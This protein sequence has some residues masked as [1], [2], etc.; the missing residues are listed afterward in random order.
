MAVEPWRANALRAVTN[1][2]D[3]VVI[4]GA[5]LEAGA[6]ALAGRRGQQGLLSKAVSVESVYDAFNHGIA[7]ARAIEAFLGY[8]YRMWERGPRYVALLGSGTMD[9]RN[10]TGHGDAL[11]PSRKRGSAHGVYLSDR[12]Y[13]DVNKDGVMEMAVGR[14]PAR[15]EEEA[16]GYVLKVEAFEGGG[17]WRGRALVASDNAD[18]GG[19]YGADAAGLMGWLSGKAVQVVGLDTMPVSVARPAVKGALEAG[20]EWMIYVGHGNSR[21]M[22]QEG[23]WR[24]E[25]V[26]GLE[27]AGR[28]GIVAAMGCLMGTY[29]APGVPSL[30][31]RFVVG[32][33]GAVAVLSST[34]MVK[35]RIGVET[36]AAVLEATY[37]EGAEARLGD[38]WAAAQTAKRG[39][40]MIDRMAYLGDPALAVGAADAPRG[41]GGVG[42]VRPGYEE[43]AGWAFAPVWADMGISTAGASDP[44]GDG[45]SNAA[46]WMAGTDPM[47]EESEF[48]VVRVVPAAGGGRELRWTSAPGRRYAVERATSVTGPYS[49]IADDV[50]ATPSENRWTDSDTP[51]NSTFFYR[52]RVK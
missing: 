51:T 42:P 31:E 40:E 4:Y 36:A 22:A 25:D 3:Y 10:Y 12:V 39:E 43:W 7:D 33:K 19:A 34:W 9:Y 32:E 23:L 21:Q 49:V 47:D 41:D 48:A 30:G 50:A 16:L 17:E 44:D 18:G 28:A 37:G 14:I 27:N 8:A 13:G 46:E 38:A 45:Q 1:R 6:E 35:N 5:G 29:A 24:T 20:V 52:V 26:A 2:A 15:T 11:V